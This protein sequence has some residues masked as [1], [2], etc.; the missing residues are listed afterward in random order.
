MNHPRSDN[1]GKRRVPVN[2]IDAYLDARDK[3]VA[4]GYG[5][6]ID[7]Q[8][9]RS[10]ATLSESEFLR[11]FAWVVLSSGMRETVVRGVFPRIADAFLGWRSAAVLVAR[12]SSCRRRAIRVYNHGP[13][14]DAILST[15][16][17]VTELGFLDFRERVERERIAFIKTLDYM[18]PATSYHL[19]KN[20]G[21]EVVK[22]DRHLVRLAESAGCRSPDD[23]CGRIARE[24]GDKLSVVDIVLWRYATLNREYE[25]MFIR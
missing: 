14:I 20:I 10:T 23:L 21:L 4:E 22:P 8:E 19:A 1:V 18:G 17:R 25:R 9:S 5:S 3:V 13:K 24:T 12:E 16:R 11:E 2:L 6:E 7:W 15:A